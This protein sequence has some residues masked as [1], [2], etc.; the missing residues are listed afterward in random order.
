MDCE[1][2]NAKNFLHAD[3]YC[4]GCPGEKKPKIKTG[5]AYLLRKDSSLAIFSVEIQAPEGKEH[6]VAAVELMRNFKIEFI[7]D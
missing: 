7:S 1:N 4:Q 6:E 5:R 2:C 3:V